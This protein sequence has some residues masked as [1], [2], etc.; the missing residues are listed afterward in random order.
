MGR[1]CYSYYWVQDGSREGTTSGDPLSPYLF[2]LCTE[3]FSSLL[4]CAKREGRLHG[5][6]IC[7]GAPGISHLFAY[8]TMIF[9]RASLMATHSIRGVLEVYRKASGQE[10]NFSI[11]SVAFSKNMSE[12]SCLDIMAELTIKRE[13]KMELYLG[14]PFMVARSKR[15][16]FAIIRD[17]IWTT[18]KGWNKKLLSQSGKEVLIKFIIQAIPTYAMDCFRLPLSLLREVQCMIANFWW[19]NRGQ[20]KI[21]WIVWHRLCE[22]KLVGGLGLRQLHLFNSAMLA[23]QLFSV[24]DPH[25]LGIASWK[26]GPCSVLVPMASG[27]G[28]ANSCVGR[29]LAPSPLL[30]RPITPAPP[31]LANLHVA[32]L[33]DPKSRD[34]NVSLIQEVFWPQDSE[35]ILSIPIS[36]AGYEDMVQSRAHSRHEM[37]WWR[38]VWQL[39]IPSKVKV[40]ILRACLNASPTSLNL[41]N[42]IPRALAACPF[43]HEKKEDVLHVLAICPFACQ[44]ASGACVGWLSR[45]VIRAR[46]GEMAEAVAAGGCNSIG[47]TSGLVR[48]SGNVVAHCLARL[49]SHFAEGVSDIPTA[50]VILMAL[51]LAS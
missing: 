39:K 38:R 48:R 49:A 9:C 47:I 44:D 32:D 28:K 17:R 34:W 42:R 13:N 21:Y 1:V 26:L 6:S 19:C 46:D 33:I 31:L 25:S 24:A 27:L 43:C 2:L 3:A 35:V 8:D 12:D 36:V 10:I 18:I 41:N 22:S 11:S 30:F 20:H 37:A 51:D 16:L 23:K 15:E 5:V 50:A 14:L 4:Q 40:F 7:W 29:P 45:C